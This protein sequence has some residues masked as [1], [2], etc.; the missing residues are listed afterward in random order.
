MYYVPAGYSGVYRVGP[1]NFHLDPP[2]FVSLAK[3]LDPLTLFIT[4]NNGEF[5][6]WTPPRT[7][8]RTLPGG[9]G[10]PVRYTPLYVVYVLL[11]TVYVLC[12][13]FLSSF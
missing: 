3:N 7:E 2:S 9:R 5:L 11:Y 4:S 12:M 10:G 6:A 13:N 8:P 1:P